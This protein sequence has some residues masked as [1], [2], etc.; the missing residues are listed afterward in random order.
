MSEEATPQTL[1]AEQLK[2]L[3]KKSAKKKPEDMLFEQKV[4]KRRVKNKLA[5]KARK[6]TRA[7]SPFRRG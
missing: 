1:T 3:L 4:N 5:R 6:I 2:E 7:M